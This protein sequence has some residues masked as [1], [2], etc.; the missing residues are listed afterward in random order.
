MKSLSTKLKYVYFT[1]KF[2]EKQN[3]KRYN[4]RIFIVS[5]WVKKFQVQ[6]SFE[7]EKIDQS[8]L[9]VSIRYYRKKN[10]SG[11][12]Q[13]KDIKGEGVRSAIV[14]SNHTPRVYEQKLWD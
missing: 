5:E 1:K 4:F 12:L 3:S 7:T 11:Q 6:V 13:H 10:V 14:P 8:I 2:F 9:E